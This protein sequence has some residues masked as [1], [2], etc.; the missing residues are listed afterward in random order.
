MLDSVLQA[1]RKGACGGALALTCAPH[2]GS[3]SPRQPF[4]AGMGFL[5][6][7]TGRLSSGVHSLPVS[8]HCQSHREATFPQSPRS[9]R[10]SSPPR[11]G[12][13]TAS[14][15]TDTARE[16]LRWEKP[17]GRGGQACGT[18]DT[19]QVRR[20]QSRSRPRRTR[21]MPLK[22][23]GQTRSAQRA[24]C[25]ALFNQGDAGSASEHHRFSF[26]SNV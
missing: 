22:G 7:C 10:D 6:W 21:E 20:G 1:E 17:Q 12:R 15:P 8:S 16:G 11:M 4:E 14:D 26:P 5:S 3:L 13:K 18:R 23:Q 2:L 9:L 25:T 19:W 24:P